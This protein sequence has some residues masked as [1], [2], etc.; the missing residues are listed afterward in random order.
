MPPK[1]TVDK[2]EIRASRK[3]TGLHDHVSH[4]QLAPAA[5][6]PKPGPPPPG[7]VPGPSPPPVPAPAPVTASPPQPTPEAEPGIAPAPPPPPP[8][9]TGFAFLCHSICADAPGPAAASSP[10]PPTRKVIAP[11]GPLGANFVSDEDGLAICSKVKPESS[12]AGLLLPG[13]RILACNGA[14]TS[15]LN[16]DELVAFLTDQKDAER[17]LTV[18]SAWTA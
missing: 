8:E 15:Q 17:E 6:A 13:D 12:I 10:P 3:F 11:P 4:D 16:H 18:A 9:I 2:T 5:S 1:L 14:D 7:P